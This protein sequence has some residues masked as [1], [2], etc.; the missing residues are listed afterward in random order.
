MRREVEIGDEEYEFTHKVTMSV[1]SNGNV[2]EVRIK[3]KWDPDLEGKDIKEL[4]YLPA[5]FEFIQEHIL[6]AIEEAR[7]KWEF[8]PLLKLQ[9]PSGYNN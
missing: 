9:S 8:E 3:V 7:I 6:P 2:K 1:Y 5:A 4:G